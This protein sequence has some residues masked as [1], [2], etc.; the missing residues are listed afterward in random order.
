[1]DCL[2]FRHE[3]QPGKSRSHTLFDRL[4]IESFDKKP[5]EDGK[6]PRHFSD[7]ANRFT[8]DGQPLD[9]VPGETQDLG[10]GV[11]LIRRI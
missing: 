3:N 5:A 11:T 6:L 1:M 7:Y 9:S 8:F 10:N 4:S 2:L